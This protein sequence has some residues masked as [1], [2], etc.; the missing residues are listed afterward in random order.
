MK[1]EKRW[2]R[3]MDKVLWVVIITAI[4]G[5]GGTGTGGIIGVILKRDSTKVVSLLLAFAGGIM[6]A[7]VNFDLI[8]ESFNPE[9]ATSEMPLVLVI[10]GVALGYCAIYI[11]NLIIDN[12]VN[13]ELA[14]ID[15]NHP[16][17]ADG[18]DEL[19]HADHLKKHTDE[20]NKYE[21][22]IAGIVM[23]CAI[24][25]HNI[26]EGM[27]IGA[28]YA[29][30][31]NEL[32]GNAGFL[33]AIVIGLHNIPEGMSVSVPLITGGMKSS[34]AVFVTALSGAST[35]IGA[36]LGLLIGLIS[37]IWLSLSLS[38][39]GGAMLYVVFGELL[40]E[41]FLMW[42][43]KAPGAMTL[44]GTLAGLILIHI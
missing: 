34:K 10:F 13:P 21:I 36:V 12:K 40:P 33:V 23:A 17:T 39:A 14:H 30:A 18:L 42:R 44:I 26:P 27:V 32:F 20:G 41:A 11:L 9:G 31:G 29:G 15:E 43:S 37:P 8:P 7:V 24:G 3:K 22:F 16:A 28:S 4:A 2:V 38:F 25:L 6:L 1:F 35:V 19:I 5:I